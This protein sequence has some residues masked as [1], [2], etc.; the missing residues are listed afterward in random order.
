MLYLKV[1]SEA[2][3]FSSQIK[4]LFLLFCIYVKI[5]WTYCDNN[6]MM[7]VRKSHYAVPLKLYSAM[8]EVNRIWDNENAFY[9]GKK[10]T[11]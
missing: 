2:W 5:H 9:E 8:S 7:Y 11:I 6:L 10:L 3:E 4:F 1:K